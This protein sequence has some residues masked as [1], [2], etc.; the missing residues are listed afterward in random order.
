MKRFVAI[1][2]AVCMLFCLASC[3]RN[4]TDW[5][6]VRFS[7]DAARESDQPPAA[8]MVPQDWVV[9]QVEDFW[10][11]ASYPIDDLSEIL[12][13]GELYLIGWSNDHAPDHSVSELFD[14][15]TLPTD[16]ALFSVDLGNGAVYG[17][18]KYQVDGDIWTKYYVSLS[19][20][21]VYEL[22]LIDWQDRCGKQLIKKIAYS[23]SIEGLDGETEN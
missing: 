21:D 17:Q 10:F 7:D 8:F 6:I 19:S 13:D 14:N 3:S 16:Q 5:K 11:F 20:H 23:Y 9:S 2:T 4:Y 1:L 22:K 15:V 12:Q 18:E